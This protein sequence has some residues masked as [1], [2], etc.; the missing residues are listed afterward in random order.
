MPYS[1]QVLVLALYVKL[2]FISAY[3]VLR[4]LPNMILR[5]RM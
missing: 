3:I 1:L 4:E 2:Y 5:S